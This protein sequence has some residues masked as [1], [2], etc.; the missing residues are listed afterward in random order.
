MKRAY[1]LCVI[2]TIFFNVNLA[3]AGK[4]DWDS[5]QKKADEYQNKH[6]GSR[7]K[8]PVKDFVKTYPKS[9]NI[10]VLNKIILNEKDKRHCK[11]HMKLANR[12]FIKKDYD[13]AIKELNRVFERQPD[14]VGGRFMRAVI[15]GRRKDYLTAWQNIMLAKAKDP[16]NELIEKFIKKLEK[17][18]PKPA[19]MCMV[20]GIYRPSPTYAY[21]M[22]SDVIERLL[23]EKVSKNFTSIYIDKFENIRGN[24]VIRIRFDASSKINDTELVAKLEKFSH[25][26]VKEK[27]IDKN[28]TSI[29]FK[30]EFH[31]LILKNKNVKSVSGLT[32][33]IK[34]VTDRTDVAISESIEKDGKNKELYCTYKIMVRKYKNLGDFF[35]LVSPYTYMFKVDNLKLEFVPNST[36]TMWKGTVEVEYQTE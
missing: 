29:N 13:R 32:E 18:S 19:N 25:G 24:L 21:E 3:Y 22:L 36:E 1:I 8:I 30:L 27:R 28:G 35:R 31:D 14:I 11:A 16:K 5:L 33:F 20:E 6:G 26:F 9:R 17:V 23:Q 10:D 4:I 7:K 15:A 12:H 2:L 34:Y